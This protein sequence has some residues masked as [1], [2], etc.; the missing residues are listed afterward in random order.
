MRNKI[1][2]SAFNIGNLG[3]LN[4]NVLK[5]KQKWGGYLNLVKNL[6]R[7]YK[8]KIAEKDKY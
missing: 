3:I 5:N 6:L 8:N 7:L 4:K 1:Y 2:V